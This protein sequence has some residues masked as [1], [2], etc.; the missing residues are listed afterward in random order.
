MPA[1]V[2]QGAGGAGA[3]KEERV[4]RR[5]PRQSGSRLTCSCW[6]TAFVVRALDTSQSICSTVNMYLRT[7]SSL[8]SC[9][10]NGKGRWTIAR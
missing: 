3:A 9:Q 10:E 7:F 6:K 5:R 1:G 2:A 4:S 8:A